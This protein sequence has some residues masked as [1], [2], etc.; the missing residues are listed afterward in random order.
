MNPPW[1]AGPSTSQ[2]SQDTPQR[3]FVDEVGNALSIFVQASI[4]GR[5]KL[6]RNIRNAG[7]V[8]SHNPNEAHVILVD[9]EDEDGRAMANDWSSSGGHVVLDLPWVKKS[10]E[11]GFAL[12]SRD[13]WGGYR[14]LV[15]GGH[16]GDEHMNDGDGTQ[17]DP[18]PTPRRT[19]VET[20]DALPNNQ[21]QSQPIQGVPIPQP[22]SFQIPNSFSN[23]GLFPFPL[24]QP[25]TPSSSQ[26]PPPYSSQALPSGTVIQPHNIMVQPQT[27]QVNVNVPVNLLATVLDIL[28]HTNTQ[29]QPGQNQIPMGVFPNQFIPNQLSQQSPE[30][31]HSQSGSS[32]DPRSSTTPDSHVPSPS[33]RR[34]SPILMNSSQRRVSYVH[35]DHSQG[36]ERARK[37]PRYSDPSEVSRSP[38]VFSNAAEGPTKSK[39][40]KRSRLFTT[41]DGQPLNFVVQVDLR[42]RKDVVQCIKSHGGVIK[43]DIVDADYVILSS[44]ST[45]FADMLLNTEA[46]QKPAVQA[47]FVHDC[48]DEGRI[49]DPTNYSFEGLRGKTKRGRPAGSSSQKSPSKDTK[50]TTSPSKSAGSSSKPKKP[51][52]EVASPKAKKEKTIVEKPSSTVQKTNGNSRRTPSPPPPTT[53]VH[54]TE[55]KHRYTEE[56]L[57]Y[58]LTYAG[59]L[60]S[61]DPDISMTSLV[62]CIHSKMP[63]HPKT[64]WQNTIYKNRA[65][66][67]E[68]QKRAAIAR[69]KLEAQA[70]AAVSNLYHERDPHLA[71][72]EPAEPAPA[73][74]QP[75]PP[76]PAQ[77]TVPPDFSSREFQII[78]QA[79]ATGVAEGR[80]D[81]Q[82]WIVLAEQHPYMSARGWR[83]YWDQYAEWIQVEVRR[84]MDLQ[85]DSEAPPNTVTGM[86]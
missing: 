59:I 74:H 34:G 11:K 27:P 16:E 50:G 67:N 52:S 83:D 82:V 65:P 61:R 6:I 9:L 5:P 75:S 26:Q 78:T 1:S 55:G 33:L 48:V 63:H 35:I 25:T 23:N 13:D 80:T 21:A 76:P 70:Q 29:M 51:V 2:L 4:E 84:L 86:G 60:Y 10:L 56:E 19:P 38:S 41:D 7:A 77:S 62:S 64:S 53:T 28:Q 3:I 47:S 85:V 40:S 66:Y 24:S 54:W 43:A 22:T 36:S 44:Q 79:L 20:C 17:H 42:N 39:K 8:I 18:L 31:M 73:T 71:P 46:H 37:R 58:A 14:V 32:A 81:E 45:S 72:M 30:L 49:L 57:N 69:R 68:L 12:L 15:D